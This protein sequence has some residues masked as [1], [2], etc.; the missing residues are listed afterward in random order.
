MNVECRVF[1]AN[2]EPSTERTVTVYRLARAASAEGPATLEFELDAVRAQGTY[3]GSIVADRVGLHD[4]WL[5][6]EVDRVAFRSFDVEVPA[7][8]MRDPRRNQETLEEVATLAGGEAF[9]LYEIPAMVE[10][11]EAMT[12]TEE[13]EIDDDALWDD[14]WVLLLLTGFLAS[15]WILRKMM[16]LL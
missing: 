7:L 5:G 12:Q 15:E 9:E 8:E 3:H 1:D 6:S 13:G 10:S 16:R 2:M 4:L 14:R 11:L